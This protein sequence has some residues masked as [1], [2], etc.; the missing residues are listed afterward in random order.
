MTGFASKTLILTDKEGAQSQLTLSLKSLNSR[1]FEATCK[2]PAALTTLETDLI[3]LLKNK[4]HRGYIVLLVQVNNPNLFKG[5][6]QA[7]IAIA[8]S[9]L[10]SIKQIQKE[11]SL[12]GSITIDDIL[13]LPNIFAAEEKT[14]DETTKKIIFDAVHTVIDELIKARMAEGNALQKDLL[15]RIEIMH[16]NI[17][18]IEKI[19]ETVMKKKKEEVNQR[20]RELPLNSQD[21]ADMQRATLYLELDKMDIHEEIVRF[22]NHLETFKKNIVS[23]EEEK[24]R[25]LDFILQELARETNTIAAKCGDAEISGHAINI[26]VEVEKA[27]EQVQNI[28]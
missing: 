5:S 25:R 16:K 27:R 26:K 17:L 12:E 24:G 14:I 20:L 3:K 13:S 8:K 21:V 23:S 15:A 4:L 1:Y 7:D 18:S 2:L 9:Y 10:E 11:C 19:F 28:V 22:N 6:V